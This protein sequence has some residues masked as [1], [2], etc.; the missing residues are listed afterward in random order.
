[1][2][3]YWNL[4]RRRKLERDI[5]EELAAHQALLEEANRANGTHRRLGSDL[6]LREHTRAAD[7]PVWLDELLRDIG[8]ARRSLWRARGFAAVAVLT[9]ALG[10]GATTAMFSVVRTFVLRSLPYPAAS[11][12]VRIEGAEAS[13]GSY[14]ALLPA[15][16]IEALRQASIFASIGA[17]DHPPLGE[18]IVRF[19]GYAIAALP[20]LASRD[21]FPTLGVRPVLGRN[22]SGRGSEAIVSAHFFQRE[23]RGKRSALGRSL[24]VGDRYYTIVGVLAEGD[25]YPPLS[26]VWLNRPGQTFKHAYL[27]GR[28]RSGMP[29]SVEEARARAALAA[30]G[31]HLNH[32]PRSNLVSGFTIAPMIPWRASEAASLAFWILLAASGCLLLIACGNTANLLLARGLDRR[33]ELAVRRAL[34]ASRTRLARL[35]TFE[36][37]WLA[38][39]SGA[40]G[41]SFA[42]V[43]VRLVQLGPAA[44][45]FLGAQGRLL[46]LSTV[47][48]DPSAL[49]LSAALALSCG[50]ACA[51]APALRLSRSRW[52]EP[53]PLHGGEQATRPQSLRRALVA[54]EI[55]VTLVLL[56]AG[57]LLARSLASLEG[58]KLGFNSSHVTEITVVATVLGPR[59]D[60]QARDIRRF[61]ELQRRLAVLPG[62]S[63][64]GYAR[65]RL[66]TQPF[67]TKFGPRRARW[68]PVGP[69]YFRTLKI[70]LLA[71]HGLTASDLDCA[72]RVGV[73]ADP[74]DACPVV[75]NAALA[76]EL[77]PGRTLA[78]DVGEREQEKEITYEVTG[79]SGNVND[80]LGAPAPPTLYTPLVGSALGVESF[81]LRSLLP[82]DAVGA[83]VLA[84]LPK[85]DAGLIANPPVALDETAQ[86][87]LAWPRFRAA[88]MAIF[89]LLAW[90]LALV[91]LYGV[92]AFQVRQRRRE[93]GV[94]VALGAGS[95]A[96]IH[97]VL[98]QSL[99]VLAA[100]VAAGWLLCW[101]LS[102]Y[103][104]SLLFGVSAFDPLTW[105][106]AGAALVAAGLLA[107]F[108]P[109]RRA[110]R[111]DAAETLRCE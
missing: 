37:L 10:I 32:G 31:D 104:A 56:T 13:P 6:A 21:F 78:Q 44:A 111:I 105:L 30:L 103:I 79:V 83:E 80:Q 17:F 65:L 9:L 66:F 38:L 101:I 41:A 53:D 11:H 69:G 98:G 68:N 99:A 64:V 76:H 86:Q 71:G 108:L 94:R 27:I 110:L 51:L 89:A 22:F 74:Q 63:S 48:L 67:S 52:N 84:A 58:V 90:V 25:A 70:P 15:R 50:L 29:L 87:V 7:V 43:L 26:Q 107:S 23:L 42:W 72:V 46:D 62:V 3:R 93:I 75:V 36:G 49:T 82:P 47:R 5:A 12:L 33:R 55:A 18:E 14:T 35:L 1:M 88:L 109:A 85:V 54:T 81:Y 57:L 61:E 59:Q 19:H 28:L 2:R 4:L 97:M 106:L 96:V 95:G 39:L 16:T 100:G 45:T 73:L 24:R 92:L 20:Q 77:W 102:R 40:L 60:M 8:F 34:G 91:G